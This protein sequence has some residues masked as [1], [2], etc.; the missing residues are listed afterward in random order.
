M[1]LSKWVKKA[2]DSG[3]TTT[4]VVGARLDGVV[5]VAVADFERWAGGVRDK[6]PRDAGGWGGVSPTRPS[7]RPYKF[8]RRY[9]PVHRLGPDAVAAA[10]SVLTRLG[11][12]ACVSGGRVAALTRCL[13]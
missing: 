6:Q 7:N 3:Q 12:A 5:Q 13:L 2:K 10:P 1:T 4:L 11:G 9:P 8:G